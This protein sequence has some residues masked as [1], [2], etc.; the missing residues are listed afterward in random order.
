[1]YTAR[2]SSEI[3]IRCGGNPNGERGGLTLELLA[4]LL[5]DDLDVLLD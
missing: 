4:H 5:D 3:E 1:M 2:S